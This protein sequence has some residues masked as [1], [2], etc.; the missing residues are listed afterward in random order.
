MSVRLSVMALRLRLRVGV[1]LR[2]SAEYAD[3]D[4]GRRGG[5]VGEEQRPHNFV[6]FQ[7]QKAQLLAR[8]C[9]DTARCDGEGAGRQ[10]RQG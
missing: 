2:T 1:R 3:C 10:G 4:E 9:S 8:V 6:S 5:T 7:V